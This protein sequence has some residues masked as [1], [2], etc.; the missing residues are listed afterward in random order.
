MALSQRDIIITPNKGAST[1]PL[2]KFT[3]ADAS[4]NAS[5]TLR[6]L[7]SSTIGTLSFEGTAGQLFSI[8]D[9]MAG[10]I[11]SVNDISGIPSIEVLDTGLIKIAQYSGNVG[12]GTSSANSKLTVAGQVESTA[13]GYKFPDGT[14]QASAATGAPTLVIVTATTQTAASGNHYVLTNAAAST[15][16]L[17]ASPV[18]GNLI[19]VTSG[20]A[21]ATN[22]IA[23]N[24][25]KIMGLSENLT[26]N[27]TGYTT[28]QLRYLNATIGWALI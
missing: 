21:L 14:V 17:P 13:T 16:T 20:N 15:L 12:I 6:V 5:I 4:S 2:I 27:T 3:G 9:S 19:Y 24:G 8:T 10:T 7:N 18:A 1:E 28:M 25:N 22:V 26:I 23:Y 11:F